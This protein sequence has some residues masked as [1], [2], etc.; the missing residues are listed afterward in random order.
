MMKCFDTDE[1]TKQMMVDKKDTPDNVILFPKIPKKDQIK[2]LL[3]L[4][5]NDRG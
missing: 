4:T 2:R 1:T 3:N 5:L